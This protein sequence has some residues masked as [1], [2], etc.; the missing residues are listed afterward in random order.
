MLPIAVAPSIWRAKSTRSGP[1]ASAQTG[2]CV[3]RTSW[4]AAAISL[5]LQR[6]Q[7][8]RPVIRVQRFR[9]AKAHISSLSAPPLNVG[10]LSYS[11]SFLSTLASWSQPFFAPTTWHIVL[12]RAWCPRRTD[13]PSIPWQSLWTT[14]QSELKRWPLPLPQITHCLIANLQRNMARTLPLRFLRAL[15]PACLSALREPPR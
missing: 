6:Q 8:A 7:S 14:T 15:G 1:A 12:A 10:T 11:G 9:A 5:R 13:S 4:N 2:G 3:Y